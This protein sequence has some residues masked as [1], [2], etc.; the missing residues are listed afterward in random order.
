VGDIGDGET[1]DSLWMAHCQVP[2]DH[3][4]EVMPGKVEALM[5]QGIGQAQ[6]IINESS[7][8]ITGDSFGFVAQV[9]PSLVGDNYPK[10]GISQGSDLGFPSKP[11]VRKSVQEEDRLP[12][13]WSSQGGMQAD[14]IRQNEVKVYVVHG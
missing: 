12:I 13:Y 14:A 3:R 4:S 11:G 10:T 9:V 7:H 1:L 5:T 2:P 8:S 6:N